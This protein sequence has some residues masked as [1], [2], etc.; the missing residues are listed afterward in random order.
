MHLLL[1][2]ALS[3]F[4]VF[5]LTCL[6]VFRSYA[7]DQGTLVLGVPPWD[8][9]HKLQQVYRPLMD[10]LDSQL[11]V[12]T[13]L[14]LSEDYAD[15]IE[16][17]KDNRVNI[18]F[19]PP[20]AYVR[21]KAE[22]SSLRVMAG[23]MDL[24]PDTGA[25]RGYYN[26]MIFTRDDA[27]IHTV[28]D[29][30]GKRIGFTDINST[31][32][33]QY[34]MHLLKQRGIEAESFFSDIKML[35]QHQ[36]V[37]EA[38]KNNKIDAGATF[39]FLYRK[40][41]QGL[42]IITK[43][44]PM[45]LDAVVI[46]EN[47]SRVMGLKLKK[48]LLTL[49][50]ESSVVKAMR[51]NGFIHHGFTE[52][53]NALYDTVREMVGLTNT[54]KNFVTLILGITPSESAEKLAHSYAPLMEFLSEQTGINTSI[55]IAKNYDDLITQIDIGQYDIGVFAAFAYVRAKNK[56]PNLR[57]LV[58]MLDRDP[59]GNI[60]QH[61]RGMIITLN[62]SP[63]KTI[64]DLRGSRM[65]FTNIYSTSGYLYPWSLFRSEDINPKSFFSEVLLLK[66]HD[67]VVNAILSN[68]ADVGAVHDYIL[69]S[70]FPQ[71][72]KDFKVLSYTDYI[73]LDAIAAG[74]HLSEATQSK[75]R[76][77]L[78]KIKPGRPILQKLKRNGWT[79]DGIVEKNDSFY[80]SVR[81]VEKLRSL[82]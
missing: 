33:Y 11:G 78:L 64:Q 23:F 9:E 1:K 79:F 36:K 66:R 4:L 34:P 12:K 26:A 74:P 57:Y 20:A 14:V 16:R 71:Q 2:K 6:M 63:Y 13:K 25:P 73:P 80:D 42:K 69:P 48:S 55:R 77:A 47:V 37:I 17:I 59:Q 51:N 49:V 24:D 67:N 50:P 39:E 81:K 10:F 40:H 53:D 62:S 3:V 7:Q 60:R 35:Q 58:S 65:A 22:I 32:G 72:Q 29:L 82:Q 61:Y 8:S 76:R 43:T 28:E 52:I 45:P 68:K 30:K 56:T 18:G 21:A 54:R 19:L 5:C 46:S 75:V 38:V 15:L 44:R 41:H 70:A 31:S 27:D